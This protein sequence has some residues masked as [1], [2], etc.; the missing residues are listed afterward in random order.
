[1]I[2]KETYPNLS[3]GDRTAVRQK[4]T[5][6]QL[7]KD[8]LEDKILAVWEFWGEM[9]ECYEDMTDKEREAVSQAINKKVNGI[10]RYFGRDYQY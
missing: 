9:A 1:M 3:K 6:N 8:L 7:A 5:P 2:Y 10:L 4:L